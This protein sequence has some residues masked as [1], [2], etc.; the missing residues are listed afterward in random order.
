M[1]LC[2]SCEGSLAPPIDEI[3]IETA[4]CKLRR[5]FNFDREDICIDLLQVACESDSFMFKSFLHA[6]IASKAAMSSLSNPMLCFG[7][8]SAVPLLVHVRGIVLLN[9]LSKVVERV[10]SLALA[11]ELARTLPTYVTGSFLD[12]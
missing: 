10:L 12:V 3:R 4:L 7:E 1:S 11:D 2:E 5:Q 6:I 8:S 9:C